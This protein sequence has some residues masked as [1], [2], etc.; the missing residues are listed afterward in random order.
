VESDPILGAVVAAK[1]FRRGDQ[2]ILKVLGSDASTFVEA[3][4]GRLEPA[5]EPGIALKTMVEPMVFGPEADEH[6]GWLPV[7]GNRDVL[8]LCK[9]QVSR[10]II[11]HCR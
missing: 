2:S 11:L 3:L 5:A 7:G 9:T 4:A 10:E 6:T 1:F 8:R